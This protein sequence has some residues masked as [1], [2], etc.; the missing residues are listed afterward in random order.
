MGNIPF[1]VTAGIVAWCLAAPALRAATMVTQLEYARKRTGGY[2][3]WTLLTV[4]TWPEW[5][6]SFHGSVPRGAFRPVPGVDAAVM[7]LVRRERRLLPPERMRSWRRLVETG[8]TGRGGSLAASLAGVHSRRRVLAA[9]ARA[10]LDPRVPV[11][12]VSPAEWLT[13][14]A[15]L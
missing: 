15:H 2:R 10:G 5:D 8:F 12:H 9:F 13:V 4:S 11:G 7:R 1:S 14:F 6:W 3:R